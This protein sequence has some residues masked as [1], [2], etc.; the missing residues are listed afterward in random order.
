MDSFYY[1]QPPNCG[2]WPYHD[3]S[4][5]YEFHCCCNQAYLPDYYIFRP[6]FPQELPPPHIYYHVPSP[7][8]PNACPSYFV[9]SHPYPFDQTPYGYEKF[10]SH[11]CGCPTHVC[12]GAEKNNVKIEEQRPDVKLESGDHKNADSDSIIQHPNKKYPFIWLPLGN[13][14][15]KENGEHYELSP[16]VL[17]EWAPVSGKWLGDVKQQGQDN[18]KGKQFQWPIVWM[19]AGYD[20]PNQK[21]KEMNDTEETPKSPKISEVSPQS[22]KIIHLSWFGNGHHHDQKSDARNGSGDHNNG[23]LVVT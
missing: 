7:H 13:M 18:E 8:H 3:I 16:Q 14:K 21:A 9:P 2:T 22:P 12:P 5:S 6:P 17:N 15:G 1:Y 11:C 19:P 20:A 23:S 4:H 10:K